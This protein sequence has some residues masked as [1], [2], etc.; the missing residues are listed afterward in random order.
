[1]TLRRFERR[2]G[3]RGGPSALMK[4]KEPA[5]GVCG[6]PDT[7]EEHPGRVPA[8]LASI[9]GTLR[10]LSNREGDVAHTSVYRVPSNFELPPGFGLPAWKGLFHCQVVKAGADK[11]FLTFWR[12]Q[13]IAE[14][15]EPE[16]VRRLGLGSRVCGG[17]VIDARARSISLRPR[18]LGDAVV[19]IAAV[20]GAWT[21]LSAAWLS[22]FG[23]PEVELSP[24]LGTL[25]VAAHRDFH[26]QFGITNK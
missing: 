8:M 19:W 2:P 25:N 9:S 11:H 16:L 17:A 14:H 15:L 6:L 5:I 26:V 12:A 24:P 10:A 22:L 20:V 23:R 4:R 13:H 3:S 21:A 7:L 18:S 1:M